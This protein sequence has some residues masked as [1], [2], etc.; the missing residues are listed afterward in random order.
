MVWV[1]GSLLAV[2]AVAG[3]VLGGIQGPLGIL[4]G[5][6]LSAFSIWALALVTRSFLQVPT[7]RK[8]GVQRTVLAGVLKFP[9]VAAMLFFGTRLSKAGFGCFIAT[10]LLVY[11]GFVAYQAFSDV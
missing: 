8:E 5:A 1:N 11:F 7:E 10:I 9:F 3:T 6:S 2:V 4:L